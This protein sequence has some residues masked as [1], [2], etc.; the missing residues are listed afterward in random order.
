MDQKPK[1]DPGWNDPP[2]LNYT[3]SNPPPKSR[4]TNKRVAFPVN[5][6]NIT[7]T[8]SQST[9]SEL[10][11]PKLPYGAP[12]LPPPNIL[13]PQQNSSFRD[14]KENLI[15]FFKTDE[16]K[17]VFLNVCDEGKLSNE[18][19]E[20]ICLFTKS[21]VENDKATAEKL[22]EKLMTDHKEICE[23]W[24]DSIDV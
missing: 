20:I 10:S 13:D 9:S 8:K 4:I 19:S 23:Q 1:V 24:L 3:T 15:P 14:M 11:Q 2:M 22:K 16:A 7:T 6:S 17:Q 12:P 5:T 18:C 21:L